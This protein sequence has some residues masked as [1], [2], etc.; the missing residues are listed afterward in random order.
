MSLLLDVFNIEADWCL[1]RMYC[2]VI[3]YQDGV[4]IRSRS[5]AA[6]LKVSKALMILHNVRQTFP[7]N[8]RTLKS[9]NATTK[10]PLYSVWMVVLLCCCLCLIA[11]GSVETI[12]SIFGITA[13]A[14]DC[15]YM[16][17]VALKLYY[18]G[19]LNLRKGPFTLGK[20]GKAVNCFALAWV[21]LAAVVLLFPTTRP[22]TAVNM[23][24]IPGGYR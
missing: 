16:A 11:L 21:S 5:R 10:T 24:V 22:I 4:R 14:L 9:M 17:V 3:R 1:Q 15:S 19:K 7:Y 23:Q 8:N 18:G 2:N 13:P 20:W 12:N 6:L